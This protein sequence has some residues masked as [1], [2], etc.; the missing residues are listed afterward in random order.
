ML[1][2]RTAGGFNPMDA[3]RASYLVKAGR[4]RKRPS[5]PARPQRPQR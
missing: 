3:H 4:H 5:R 2:G 1:K